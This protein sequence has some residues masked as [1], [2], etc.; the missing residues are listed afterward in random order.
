LVF[1]DGT[2][3]ERYCVP[4]DFRADVAF[5]LAEVNEIGLGEPDVAIDACAFVEP[6]VA[7]GGIDAK[8]NGV[9]LAEVEKVGEVEAEGCVAVVIA[10]NEAAVDEDENASEG[11][12]ELDDDAL[13]LIGGGDVEEAAIPADG[14][15]RVA[16]A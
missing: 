10:T 2:E 13:A 11:A 6:A 16:A 5:P 4:F 12:V 1:N 7:E 3:C 8:D 9:L 14:G 15:L